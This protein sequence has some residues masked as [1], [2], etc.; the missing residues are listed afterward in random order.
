MSP[1]DAQP[2]E[3]LVWVLA[4]VFIIIV[5]TFVALVVDELLDD[6]D[7]NRAA[8]HAARRERRQP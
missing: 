2:V 1:T 8:R 3:V 7:P 6:R 4:A 5:S